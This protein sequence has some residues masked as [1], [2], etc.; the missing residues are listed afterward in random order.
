MNKDSRFVTKE[1]RAFIAKKCNES[2]ENQIVITHGTISMVDSAKYLDHL[3]IDKSIILTGAMIPAN[4]P[5]TDAPENVRLAFS[6]VQRLPAG[7]Y[8]S[9]S[10]RIF[11]ANNVRKNVEKGI[12]EVLSK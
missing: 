1:D 5:D 3:G 10:R 6:E 12:F 11:N 7:V 8:I 2:A 4:K 9:M